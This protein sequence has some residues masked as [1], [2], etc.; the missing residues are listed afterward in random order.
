[1]IAYEVDSKHIAFLLKAELEKT[2]SSSA[3]HQIAAMA[4]LVVAV[5]LL[6]TLLLVTIG[7]LPVWLRVQQTSNL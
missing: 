4:L 7:V 5:L 1:M 2:A 3:A 6:V